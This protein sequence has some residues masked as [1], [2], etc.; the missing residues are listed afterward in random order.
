MNAENAIALL[1]PAATKVRDPLGNSSIWLSGM[2]QR[3]RVADGALRFDLVFK[4]E[5]TKEQRHAVTEGLL[6]EL[7]AL[8]YDGEVVPF[9]RLEGSIA[10]DKKAQQPAPPPPAAPKKDAVPGMTGGGMAPH[11]GPVQ[12]QP[13]VGVKRLI[14]VASGKGGVGKSTVS[15]NLAVALSRMGFRVGLLDA[16]VH[17]PSLPKMMGAKGPVYVSPDEKMMPIVAHGVQCL[18]V[19]L[20][21]PEEEAVIWRGPMVMDMVR[22]LLQR[23]AWD[24]DYLVVDL[25]PGT[26]DA[27]LTLIQGTD[28]HGAVIVTT[29]QDVA[30]AD[31]IRGVTMFRKLDVPLVGIVENMSFYELPDG[32]RDYVFG[33]GGGRR[34]AEKYA[35]ELL[36]ELPL[37]SAVRKSGDEGVPSAVG[38]DATAQAFAA[39]AAKVAA[40][41]P[42]PALA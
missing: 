12:K 41:V 25:P 8:G 39:L 1:E 32:S 37:R 14:V 17:G 29:P 19:G 5:Y 28:I 22:R 20:I 18:S 35:T 42:L 23:A 30:L 21:V 4:R 15:T 7:R 11:G 40:K 3:P 6:G 26:G 9:P 10:A 13:L 38:D 16:D 24:V 31:A 2:V 34:M 33:E 36:V 27:Q